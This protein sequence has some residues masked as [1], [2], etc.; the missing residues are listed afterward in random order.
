MAACIASTSGRS[1]QRRGGALPPQT[2]LPP[3]NLLQNW[4]DTTR[5]AEALPSPSAKTPPSPN[6]AGSRF[7]AFI[8]VF[9][10]CSCRRRGKRRLLRVE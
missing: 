7:P 5:G 4:T 8:I 2:H 9:M 6:P 1:C 10:R 3:N